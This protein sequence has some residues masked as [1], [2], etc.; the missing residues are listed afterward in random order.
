MD[1]R[2]YQ[3]GGL[4]S[5]P[6]KSTGAQPNFFVAE[7]Q[8]GCVQAPQ[9]NFETG[10]EEVMDCANLIYRLVLREILPPNDKY[11]T[12]DY[13]ENVLFPTE[14]IFIPIDLIP[15]I[16]TYK[17]IKANL[18]IVNAALSLFSFRGVILEGF[19]PEVDEEKLDEII[20]D[21]TPAPEPP[22]PIEPTP[23]PAN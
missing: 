4:I 3:Q 10:K 22:A 8:H 15:L 16:V 18:P 21:M 9:L 5:I 19:K 2:L 1:K 13:R 6:L 7:Q 20:A 12:E 11:T 14:T 23:T 17:R